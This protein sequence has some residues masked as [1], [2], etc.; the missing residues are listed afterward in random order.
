MTEPNERVR[1]TADV[2]MTVEWI[3]FP[4]A[5]K[6]HVNPPA[7]VLAGQD[8]DAELHTVNGQ[9]EVVIQPA[10]KSP[11]ALADP[12]TIGGQITHPVMLTEADIVRIVRD[13]LGSIAGHML[14]TYGA[15]KEA[16]RLRAESEEH[17]QKIDQ[18]NHAAIATWAGMLLQELAERHR[19][20]AKRI[21][22]AAHRAAAGAPASGGDATTDDAPTSRTEEP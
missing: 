21:Q 22:G 15:S 4:L 17:L 3:V 10:K 14:S 19:N 11:G 9:A 20:E 13:E 5:G 16:Q 6:V 12:E 1:F 18:N 8:Y 7:D 2:D